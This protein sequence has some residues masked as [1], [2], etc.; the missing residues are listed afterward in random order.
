MD[1][2]NKIVSTAFG[3]PLEQWAFV[4]ARI[5]DLNANWKYHVELSIVT[6]MRRRRSH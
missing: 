2:C 6:K 3:E 5:S 1:L 4:S